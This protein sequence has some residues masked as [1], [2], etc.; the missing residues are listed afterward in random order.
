MEGAGGAAGAAGEGAREGEA[1]G[2]S[3][4]R[5]APAEPVRAARARAARAELRPRAPPH[6]SRH[7]RSGIPR[8]RR[9]PWNN[10]KVTNTVTATYTLRNSLII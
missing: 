8:Y 9:N 5:A 7:T 2:S 10:I 3:P 6:D 4:G 1:R